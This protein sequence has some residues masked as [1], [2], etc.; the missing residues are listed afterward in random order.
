MARTLNQ[1]LEN[2]KPEVVKKAKNLAEKAILEL[3]LSEKDK[4]K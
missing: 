2:E 1:I 3:E 4:R